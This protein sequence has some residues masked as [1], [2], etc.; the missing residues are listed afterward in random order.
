MPVI[1]SNF[2]KSNGNPSQINQDGDN[3]VIF[4]ETR[5]HI[6]NNIFTTNNT[7]CIALG[8]NAFDTVNIYNNSFYNNQ[9]IGVF[10]YNWGGGGAFDVKNNLFKGNYKNYE[11]NNS[12]YAFVNLTHNAFDAINN[13][14]QPSVNNFVVSN[15]NNIVNPNMD[16]SFDTWKGYQLP[17]LSSQSILLGQGINLV[18]NNLDFY[19]NNRPQP[20]GS[21]SDIG[22][23]ESSL[24]QPQISMVDSMS[25]CK[26][27]SPIDLLSL[28]NPKTGQ[29]TGNGVSA[30]IFY[31]D[32]VTSGVNKIYYTLSGANWTTTIDS[33][34][35]NV[36]PIPTFVVTPSVASPYCIGTPVQLNASSVTNATY[37]WFQK[38]PVVANKVKTE[39]FSTHSGNGSQTQYGMTPSNSADFNKFFD[40][41]YSNTVK[42][43]SG[44][45]NESSGLNW[46]G[47][48]NLAAQNVTVPNNGNYFAI[49][50]SGIKQ[51]FQSRISVYKLHL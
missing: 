4:C 51:K 30:N 48:T 34:L 43:Y 2:F 23:I 7:P 8:A 38:D 18:N 17:K 5:G 11:Y 33:I 39:V 41:I 36:L 24:S 42:V 32:S 16:L 25:I 1:Q 12:G 50:Y 49:Q 44:F 6:S 15:S 10:F 22:A 47:Y 37:S 9:N 26:N 46:S 29:F 19:K 35:I 14:T 21:N 40:T 3:G 27:N 13:V 20:A 28:V 31:P 45:I